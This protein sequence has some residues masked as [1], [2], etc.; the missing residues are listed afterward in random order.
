MLTNEQIEDIRTCYAAATQ[1]PVEPFHIPADCN[2]LG[3]I[4]DCYAKNMQSDVYGVAIAPAEKETV[5]TAMTGNG[6]TSLANARFYAMCHEVVPLFLEDRVNLFAEIHALENI[7]RLARA[8]SNHWDEFGAE[9]DLD[10][11]MHALEQAL[12][13]LPPSVTY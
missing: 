7:V 11:W 9:A 5:V 13:E 6:P 2:P 4:T 1:A 10:E 8:A 12:Q 3:W